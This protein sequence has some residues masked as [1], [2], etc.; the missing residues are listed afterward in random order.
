MSRINFDVVVALGLVFMLGVFTG[1]VICDNHVLAWE[2]GN[3]REDY[4]LDEYYRLKQR[5]DQRERESQDVQ[6]F[7]RP[8]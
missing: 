2:S 8:C 1:L 6:S 7:R 5:R 3:S 4:K